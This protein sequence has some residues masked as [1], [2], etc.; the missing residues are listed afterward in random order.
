MEPP[1]TIPSQVKELQDQVDDVNRRQDNIVKVLQ[2]QDKTIMT[3]DAKVQNLT[4]SAKLIVEEILT[5]EDQTTLG[6]ILTNFEYASSYVIQ[7]LDETMNGLTSLINN[8]LH[9]YFVDLELIREEYK[10]LKGA[11]G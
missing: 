8:K 2:L 10:R 1:F 4:E 6:N 11:V 5:L 3:L 9:P 7:H